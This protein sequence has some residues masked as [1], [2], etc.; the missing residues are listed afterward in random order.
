MRMCGS[1][2]ALL[3]MTLGLQASDELPVPREPKGHVLDDARL[4]SYEAER[5]QNLDQ[6]I[7][8]FSERT[9]YEVKVAFFDSLI[10]E[11]LPEKVHQLEDHWLT[12]GAGLVLVVVTDN[13]QWKIGWEETPEMVTEGGKHVPV[14]DERDIAP[15]QKVELVTRMSAVPKME[16]GS[17]EDAEQL[18]NVLLAGLEEAYS[19]IAEEQQGKRH[20]VKVVMLGLALLS[21]MVLAAIGV[22]VLLRRSDQRKIQPMLFP[23]VTVRQRLGASAGGGKISSRS[24]RDARPKAEESDA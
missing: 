17:I 3:L 22:G 23:D 1:L 18:V 24:F 4:F 11:T 12:D 14:I 20:K 7:A 19:P 15:Q 9:G 2:L 6:K 16:T 8:S 21:A 13:G 10:G 5:L